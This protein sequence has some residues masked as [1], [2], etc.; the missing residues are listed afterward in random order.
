[1]NKAHLGIVFF[2]TLLYFFVELT[3]GLYFNSLALVT[4]ASFMAVNLSG[5]LLAIYTTRLSE[6][7]PDKQ[8]T[9]GYERAKVL[10]GLFSGIGIGFILFYVFGDAYRRIIKPEPL[11]ADYVFL[12]AVIGLLVNLFG[13]VILSRRSQEI[14]I[15]GAFLL[16]LNDLLGSVG[17]ITAALIIRFTGLY[18]VDAVA[19]IVMG[20]F[21]IY[22]TYKLVKGSIDILMEGI[23]SGIDIEEVAKFITA[24]LDHTTTIKGLHVWALV[25]EK[26]LMA[27]KIR[28]DG[29]M[30][31]R[32]SIKTLKSRLKEKFGFSDVYIEIYEDKN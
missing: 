16:V 26:V 18:I 8:R 3:G 24:N 32:E 29:K 12:I 27:V 20:L 15:R 5:Q 21:I 30:H 31:H 4:D 13:V 2:V 19:S 11:D 25:P 6:R 28:T 9:F 1:M 22:P 10:S 17:V 23:P 14:N 7:P